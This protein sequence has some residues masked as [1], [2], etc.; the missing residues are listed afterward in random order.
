MKSKVATLFA[1]AF[2]LMTLSP[3]S[4]AAEF[5]GLNYDLEYTTVT[6]DLS[7]YFDIQGNVTDLDFHFDVEKNMPSIVI[8][9]RIELVCDPDSSEYNQELCEV[10]NRLFTPE[11][12]AWLDT[13]W[14][15]HMSTAMAVFPSAIQT[16]QLPWPVDNFGSIFLAEYQLDWPCIWDTQSGAFN[17]IP[18]AYSYNIPLGDM[19][20]LETSFGL[21]G[22]GVVD[23]SKNYSLDGAFDFDSGL[24]FSGPD[25]YAD[26]QFGLTANYINLK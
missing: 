20:T 5:D 6:G 4:M 25:L 10:L 18:L 15:M 24:I 26:I 22:N 12:L 19:F 3:A 13:E 9:E 14:N 17:T 7:L 1:I 23:R 16:R 21:V 8:A 11:V 2:V